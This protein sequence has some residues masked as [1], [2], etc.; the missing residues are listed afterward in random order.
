MNYRG[1]YKWLRVDAC[2]C[3][4]CHEIVPPYDRMRHIG[5]HRHKS[6]QEE[7]RSKGE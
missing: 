1:W 2:E 3:Q 6:L 5:N 4:K 7:S